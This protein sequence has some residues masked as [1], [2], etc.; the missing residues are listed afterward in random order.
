[1]AIHKDTGDTRSYTRSMQACDTNRVFDKARWNDSIDSLDS[2]YWYI[3]AVCT[4]VTM[5][6]F[7]FY[8]GPFST[9]TL[10]DTLILMPGFYFRRL[11]VY[12]KTDILNFGNRELA[13][14]YSPYGAGD[15]TFRF[16]NKHP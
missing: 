11:P 5:E 2:L 6:E 9:R 8:E 7:R 16:F 1:M 4:S 10:L 13:M 14:A 15:F 12:L 3:T